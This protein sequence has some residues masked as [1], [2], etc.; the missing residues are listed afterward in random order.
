MRGYRNVAAVD[1]DGVAEVVI[2]VAELLVD[3]PNVLEIDINPLLATPAGCTALDA[4][5]RVAA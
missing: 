5:I 3:F 1:I 2:K 4:R